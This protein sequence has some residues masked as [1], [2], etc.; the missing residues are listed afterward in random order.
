MFFKGHITCALL[1]LFLSV[2]LTAQENDP[3]IA[4]EVPSH[5]MIKYNQFFLNPTFSAVNQQ[6]TYL[7]FYHRNQW[8]EF[9]D[10]FRTYLA[11]Y[12][13]KVQEKYGL[14]LSIYHQKIGVINNFGIVGNYAYEVTINDD[15]KFTLGMNISYYNSGFDK[16]NSVTAEPD[17]R[18]AEYQVNSLFDIQPGLNFNYKNWHVGVTAAN[19][20]DFNLSDKEKVTA[21]AEKTITGH[22]LYVNPLNSYGI[23]EDGNVNFMARVQKP[24]DDAINLSGSILL[25]LPRAGWA[26]GGYD[27][28]Y[29]ISAGIG[30]H[31]NNFLS[32][33]FSYE[34]GMNTLVTNM[35][36][37]YEVNFTYNIS[38]A[39]EG[40]PSMIKN[41]VEAPVKEKEIKK[42]ITSDKKQKEE[43][44]TNEETKKEIEEL[45]K[46][47]QPSTETI[48]NTKTT[49][50]EK[51][52]S[53]SEVEKEIAALEAEIEALKKHIEDINNTLQN[54]KSSTQTNQTNQAIA[55]TRKPIDKIE[56]KEYT[57]TTKKF[58]IDTENPS[59]LAKMTDGFYVVADVFTSTDDL[60]KFIDKLA[61][62]GI[63]AKSFND[64]ESGQ[65]YAYL[66]HYSSWDEAVEA[67]QDKYGFDVWI[68]Q[69]NKRT[70]DGINTQTEPPK[71]VAAPRKSTNNSTNVAEVELRR[72]DPIE[73]RTIVI[74][75]MTPGYYIVPGVFEDRNNAFRFIE[76]LQNYGL[77]PDYFINPENDYV[78]IYLKHTKSWND[79][80]YQYYSS[81]DNTYIWKNLDNAM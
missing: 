26:H 48:A 77:N 40:R 68:M 36:E 61:E 28:F 71:L 7:S 57:V 64:P 55:E 5:N 14:G 52:K 27:Q 4:I 1:L 38:A 44:V 29:G 53:T 2:K 41:L 32:L 23:F 70:K 37:T 15:M 74:P 24:G 8:N 65:S 6:D 47:V 3:F 49:T 56:E 63:N 12:G 25:D 46:T 45:P 81:L 9:T 50:S 67:A 30:F 22:L 66:D 21:L 20:F 51:I 75:N 79:A 18:I 11:T 78:Y 34:K 62:R 80:M 13:S 73:A 59:V 17:P 60:K 33:G 35:G 10:N 58:E 31:L 69:I 19:F 43:L 72:Q 16:V 42:E 39:R 76:R 54:T